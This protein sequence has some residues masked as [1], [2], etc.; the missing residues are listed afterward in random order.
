MKPTVKT[1]YKELCVTYLIY[2]P[3]TQD[4]PENQEGF[5]LNETLLLLV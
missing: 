3:F 4:V 1:G 2:F 5:Q